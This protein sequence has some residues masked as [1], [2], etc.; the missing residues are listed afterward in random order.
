MGAHLRAIWLYFFEFRGTNSFLWVNQWKPQMSRM[1]ALE[2]Y[3][4]LVFRK[5]HIVALIGLWQNLFQHKTFAC[6]RAINLSDRFGSFWFIL[7]S[8][9]FLTLCPVG[10][11]RNYTLTLSDKIG[12]GDWRLWRESFLQTGSFR[13]K[14]LGIHETAVVKLNKAFGAL[15]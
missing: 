8:D 13:L 5:L 7:T 2:I 12:L 15:L 14:G 10:A 9:S 1:P 6:C 11:D 4:Y 3:S